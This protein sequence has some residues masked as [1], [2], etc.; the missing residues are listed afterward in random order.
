M[1]FLCS[2]VAVGTLVWFVF[3]DEPLFK[4]GLITLSLLFLVLA[5]VLQLK[6]SKQETNVIKR[7]D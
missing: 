4:A 5:L 7:A 1:R 2:L 6:R 3:M